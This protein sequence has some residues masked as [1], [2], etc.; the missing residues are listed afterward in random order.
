MTKPQYTIQAVAKL[1][2]AM[3]LCGLLCFNISTNAIAQKMKTPDFAYPKTVEKNASANLNRAV[4]SGDWSA[5]VEAAIQ[6]VVASNLVSKENATTGIAKIDS[7]A[8]LA[9][10]E[11]KPAFLLIKADIYNS[12]Y[13]SIQW[14]ANSRQIPTDSVPSNPYEWSRDIFALKILDICKD[15][16]DSKE[17]TNLS[18]KEWSKFIENTSDAFAFGMT[19]EEFLCQR[20]FDLLNTYADATKD[21][22]PFFTNQAEPITPGQKCAALRDVAINQLIDSAASGKRMMILAKALSDQANALPYSLRMKAFLEAYDRL[23]GSE[24]E[25]MILGNLREYI[26]IDPMPGEESVFPYS[27]QE[28]VALLKASVADYPKGMYVNNLKNIINSLSQPTA[29]ISYQDQYLTS[30]DISMSMTLKNCN[31]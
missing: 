26:S 17:P 3:F 8:A 6:S 28:Y 9:P 19:V 5:A 20:S 23:K 11:W 1:A 31:E 10:S 22:I 7:V 25:Q 21:V 13:N 12:I 24:G 2:T 16:I 29:T 30:S 14:Q 4:A 27:A 18:L 15:V